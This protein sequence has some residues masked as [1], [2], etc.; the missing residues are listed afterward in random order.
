MKDSALIDSYLCYLSPHIQFAYPTDTTIIQKNYSAS[1][2]P[3]GSLE[4]G[5]PSKITYF[6][7]KDHEKLKKAEATFRVDTAQY[8]KHGWSEKNIEKTVKQRTRNFDP[9]YIYY[10][11]KSLAKYSGLFP[12]KSSFELDHIVNKQERKKINL[13]GE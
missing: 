1:G 10:Y 11:T 8:L 9:S 6:I 4:C 7:T 5:P 2:Q 12:R 13:Q 3:G